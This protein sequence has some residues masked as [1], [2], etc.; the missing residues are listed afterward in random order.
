MVDEETAE[1]PKK[2][3]E[4]YIYVEYNAWEC[5]ASE[6][7]WAALVAKIYHE[8]ILGVGEP[9]IFNYKWQDL[10]HRL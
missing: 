1:T 8:V 2:T 4:E 9:C 10:I 6:V 7:L 3:N 5:Q